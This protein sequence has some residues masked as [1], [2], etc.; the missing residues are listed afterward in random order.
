MLSLCFPF[1]FLDLGQDE[2]SRDSRVME[3]NEAKSADLGFFFFKSYVLCFCADGRREVDLLFQL[4][5]DQVAFKTLK[6]LE[7]ELLRLIWI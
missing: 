3:S 6:C 1:G 4:T 2:L 7:A 5:K